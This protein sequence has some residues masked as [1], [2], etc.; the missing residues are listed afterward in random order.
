MVRARVMNLPPRLTS[1]APLCLDLVPDQRSDVGPS[2]ALD[3]AYS[4]GRG[5]IDLGQIPINHVNTNKQKSAVAESRSDAL[6]DLGLA[7]GQFCRGRRAAAYHVG[8]QVV[9]GRNTIDCA[10]ILPIDEDNTLVA[11]LDVGEKFLHHPL[12]AECACEKIVE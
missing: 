12:L 8:T 1:S 10:G 7:L 2:E 6:A 5:N 9:G 3:R 4:G 11:V